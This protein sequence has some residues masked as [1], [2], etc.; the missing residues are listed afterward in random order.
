MMEEFNIRRKK[1]ANMIEQGALCT[2]FVQIIIYNDQYGL[3]Y[4][5]QYQPYLR[6]YFRIIVVTLNETGVFTGDNATS[7][8]RV[9]AHNSLILVQ[10]W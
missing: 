3:S 1:L 2:K 5:D 6:K 8:A 10:N 9:G 7:V 4:N